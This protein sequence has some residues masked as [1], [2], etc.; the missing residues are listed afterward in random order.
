MRLVGICGKAGSG[1]SA[2]SQYLVKE[3]GYEEVSFAA[4]LKRM[5]AA[6]GMSE[7]TDRALKEANVEG[8]D[9]AWRKAAQTLGDEWGRQCLDPDIWVKLTMRSLKHD[10]KYVLSD[11]R[12]TNES[13]AIIQS[14]GAMVHLH[15]RQVDLGEL[16]NHPSEKPLIASAHAHHIWNDK[17]IEHLYA[18]VRGIADSLQWQEANN[19]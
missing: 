6:A 3:Y 19:G 2:V 14:G 11:V 10:G 7:P 5:L 1:K 17:S 18:A 9:F 16:S 4:T 12:Y 8:F 15:G 13:F